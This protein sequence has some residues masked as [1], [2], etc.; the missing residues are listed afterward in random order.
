MKKTIS[1]KEG[2]DLTKTVKGGLFIFVMYADGILLHTLLFGSITLF[3]Q[4]A[5]AGLIKD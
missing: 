1:L 4:N 2:P 5:R 3:N